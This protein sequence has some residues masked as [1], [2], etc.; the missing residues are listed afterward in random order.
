M[1]K[2]SIGLRGWRFDESEVFDDDGAYL[3][4]DEMP[5]DVRKRIVRLSALVTKPCD[6]CWLVH[7]D[8]EIA[9]ANVAAVV[10][11]EPLS[12]VLLCA[13]HENDFLY[14]YRE[15]GG[16]RYRGEDELQD[17][18][19]EWFDD[20]SRAPDDY[21]GV[22]HVDTDPDDLPDPPIPERVSPEDFDVDVGADYP[23]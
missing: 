21:A 22:E 7:G 2:V 19:Y 11:G 5:P 3:P 15:D 16:S 23:K 8:E 18:F 1:G 9:R 17:A 20:G 13:E 6:A 14:W 4:I 12:E 10:Y